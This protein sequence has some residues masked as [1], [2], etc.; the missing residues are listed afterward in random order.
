MRIWFG[1]LLLILASGAFGAAQEVRDFDSESQKRLFLELA[2]ELRCP[3]C[4]NQNIAD[5]NANIAKDLRNKVF[6]LVKEG[7][8]KQQVVDFMVD[9]YGY[10]VYYKPPVTPGTIVLWLLPILFVLFTLTLIWFKSRRSQR[11]LAKAD[12]CDEQEQELETLIAQFE[13]VKER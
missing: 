3:K 13:Q 9:R 10:F 12:W 11:A 5:S 4:Q 7:N 8:D 6:K 1:T 2:D